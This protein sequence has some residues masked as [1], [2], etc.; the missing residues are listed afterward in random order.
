M[1][2]VWPR[3]S[4]SCAGAKHCRRAG[5]VLIVD[6]ASLF[7]KGRAQNFLDLEHAATIL[8]WVQRFAEVEDRARVVTLEEIAAEDWTL[9]I[10]R[11]VL[12]P[13]G[14]DIPP[15]DEAVR[16]FKTALARVREAEE[17]PA[18]G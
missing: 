4:W 10:S 12:P 2:P 17:E 8:Q 13:I 14:A 3:A 16:D 9:N 15:L 5:K 6:A 1:A 11:Y 18:R 7:R